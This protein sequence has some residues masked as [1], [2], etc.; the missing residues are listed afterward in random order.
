MKTVAHSAA[1]AKQHNY[2]KLRSPTQPLEP[3]ASLSTVCSSLENEC[4]L[5]HMVGIGWAV[6]TSQTLYQ[7][8]CS[9]ADPS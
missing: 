2:K 9:I 5:I 7:V 1:K 4:R 3:T 6:R 8:L